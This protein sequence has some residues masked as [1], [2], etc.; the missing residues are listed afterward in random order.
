V[1]TDLVR[2]VDGEPI[3]GTPHSLEPVPLLLRRPG[4]PPAPTPRGP[5]LDRT[6]HPV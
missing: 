3:R 5:G 4:G 1:V 6:V 2:I